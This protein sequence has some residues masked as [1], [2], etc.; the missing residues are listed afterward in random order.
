VAYGG[1]IL[2][3]GRG[4]L[5]MIGRQM[6][7]CRRPQDLDE[8]YLAYFLAAWGLLACAGIAAAWLTAAG[9]SIYGAI[10]LVVSI[11]LV[12]L[13]MARIIAETG[14]IFATIGANVN[15]TWGIGANLPERIS[16]TQNSYFLGSVLNY[17]T[18]VGLRETLSVYSTHALRVDDA[19]PIP[20][21]QRRWVI[22]LLI[23]SLAL[24]Y[25]TAGASTLLVE[26]THAW[27][28]SHNPVPLNSSVFG[29][30]AP[31][32]SDAGK[33]T[34][35]FTAF[36]ERFGGGTGPVGNV[37]I[38]IGITGV[39]AIM[40]LRFAWWPLHPIGYLLWQ[41]YPLA[42]AWFSLFVGW[43]VKGALLKFGGAKFYKQARP[44]FIGLIFGE[45]AAAA[46]W[47]AVALIA[48]AVGADYHSVFILPQ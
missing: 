29:N 30:C 1:M 40:R 4:H 21:R 11:L 10:V 22:P 41:S 20:G 45:A 32:L 44:F 14:L 7:L 27:T 37:A 36:R 39:L 17:V 5:A 28:L 16:T 43:M 33:Y 24:G 46:I 42:A 25:V 26:Y 48:A 12:V 9:M 34:A 35:P 8:P 3:I 47:L 13:V 31:L 2:W 38:G 18:V 15:R 6:F 19:A 23:A